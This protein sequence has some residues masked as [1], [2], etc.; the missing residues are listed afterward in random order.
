METNSQKSE[1]I[2]QRSRKYQFFKVLLVVTLETIVAALFL[3]WSEE[4]LEFLRSG[5]NW[6]RVHNQFLMITAILTNICNLLVIYGLANQK[7]L[8]LIIGA[9]QHALAGIYFSLTGL[10][11][12]MAFLYYYLTGLYYLKD[13]AKVVPFLVQV[14]LEYWP[15][16]LI[17]LGLAYWFVFVLENIQK[18]VD[19]MENDPKSMSDTQ[20]V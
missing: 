4:V 6:P 14:S 8:Y 18:H 17:L 16:L 3:I 1:A 20:I 11:Y 7:M 13:I 12:D 5:F 10:Y 9:F 19:N 15:T 2:I